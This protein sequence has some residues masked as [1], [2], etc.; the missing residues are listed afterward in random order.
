MNKIRLVSGSPNHQVI[1]LS[2]EGNKGGIVNE[3]LNRQ[4]IQQKPNEVLTWDD[5]TAVEL[6][7]LR[8]NER[9]IYIS[10]YMQKFGF[11]PSFK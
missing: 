10:L 4:P 1:G 3:L 11:S 9:A 5:C 7:A 6:A 2:G 8:K